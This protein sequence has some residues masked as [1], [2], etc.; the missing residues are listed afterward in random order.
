MHPTKM[1]TDT[2]IGK[3]LQSARQKIAV[4]DQL[5]TQTLPLS[6]DPKVLAVAFDNIH[7]AVDHA[8]NALLQS[9]GIEYSN[10]QGNHDF[11]IAEFERLCKELMLNAAHQEFVKSVYVLKQKHSKSNVEFARKGKYVICSDDYQMEVLNQKV[12]GDYL[13]MAKQLIF[14]LFLVIKHDE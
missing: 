5:L 1:Q 14:E 9:R 3:N 7:G 10:L 11:K 2:D 6:K 4:A 12:V 13:Q 8:I